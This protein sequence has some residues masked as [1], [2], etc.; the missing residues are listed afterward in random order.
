MGE[1]SQ[2]IVTNDNL[3]EMFEPIIGEITE[4]ELADMASVA[5]GSSHLAEK[6][7]R[8]E[9][10]LEEKRLRDELGCYDMDFDDL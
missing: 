10:L 2:E 1:R 8:A 7:R 6:R 3:E 5:G 9:Q 4:Q